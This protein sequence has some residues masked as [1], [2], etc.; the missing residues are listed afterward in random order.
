MKATLTTSLLAAAL[1]ATTGPA[2]AETTRDC[3]LEGTV[4]KTER[5]GEEQM[6]VKFHSME[7]YDEDARCRNRK[8]E[9]MEFKLPEDTRLQ[10]APSSWK[11]IVPGSGRAIQ[12]RRRGYPPRVCFPQRPFATSRRQPQTA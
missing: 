10:D 5:G 1:L 7:K 3:I 11:R 2:L 4:Y 8:G 9:K 12:A 6:Q